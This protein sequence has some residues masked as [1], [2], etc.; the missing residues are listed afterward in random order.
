MR[1]NAVPLKT[2]LSALSAGGSASRWLVAVL[3]ITAGLLG[4]ARAQTF[5]VTSSPLLPVA[6]TVFD[7]DTG[8]DVTLAG[9]V[10][11]V[12]SSIPRHRCLP[13]TR[14]SRRPLGP[15][16]H[17]AS[18]IWRTGPTRSLLTHVFHP[19]PYSVSPQSSGS[20]PPTLSVESP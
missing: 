16:C 7:Q 4:A 2:M 6:G 20:G 14:T 9:Q 12:P 10:H 5:V 18:G 8:E 1:L 13:C 19:P 15:G 11:V 17:P 3:V